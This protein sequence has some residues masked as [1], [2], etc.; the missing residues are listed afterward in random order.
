[1]TKV[2][3]IVSLWSEVKRFVTVGVML[4]ADPEKL[5]RDIDKPDIDRHRF[6]KVHQLELRVGSMF[7]DQTYKSV[8][9]DLKQAIHFLNLKL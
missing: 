5:Q 9:P 8:M 6:T 7:C 2:R 4:N 1:M 3:R